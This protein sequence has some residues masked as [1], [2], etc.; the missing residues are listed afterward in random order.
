MF[1]LLTYLLT[2]VLT[3][4]GTQSEVIALEEHKIN[5]RPRDQSV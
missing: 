2:R 4:H 5:L 3:E 1:Y